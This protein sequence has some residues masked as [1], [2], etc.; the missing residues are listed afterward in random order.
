MLHEREVEVQGV[1]AAVGPLEQRG[2]PDHHE[3]DPR[4]EGVEVTAVGRRRTD[5]VADAPGVVPRA[6][7]RRRVHLGARPVDLHPARR[8]ADLVVADEVGRH[9][10]LVAQVRALLHPRRD[11]SGELDVEGDGLD[12][13][14]LEHEPHPLHRFEHLVADRAHGGGL[15]R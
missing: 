10:E 4:R 13:V 6:H 11:R 2:A 8:H 5:V 9:P 12:V 3:A 1:A 15:G 14:G 7:P